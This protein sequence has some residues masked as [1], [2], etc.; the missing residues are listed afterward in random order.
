MHSASSVLPQRPSVIAPKHNLLTCTP[1][2]P[3][4]VISMRFAL[5]SAALA[6]SIGN[7][8]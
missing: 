8:I 6:E 3:S 5:L 2:R 1:A 7:L 4:V